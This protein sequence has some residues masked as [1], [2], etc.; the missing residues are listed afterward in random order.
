M[1]L[2]RRKFVKTKKRSD[3][4]ANTI[5]NAE[6]NKET[7]KNT[8]VK[9]VSVN[10][11]VKEIKKE[12]KDLDG[13]EKEVVIKIVQD[14]NYQN[15]SQENKAQEVEKVNFEKPYH[16]SIMPAYSSS[17]N[18]IKDDLR[19]VI[20]EE[21]YRK[22]QFD[23]Q[24]E[25]LKSHINDKFSALS[26][27]LKQNLPYQNQ[28]LL[29][30]PIMQPMQQPVVNSYDFFGG[31]F[32]M[33]SNFTTTPPTTNQSAT[34][35]APNS[36][37]SSTN[38]SASSESVLKENAPKEKE[39]IKIQ[40]NGK[41]VKN[42]HQSINNKKNDT[43]LFKKALSEEVGKV[44]NNLSN[45]L[46]SSINNLNNYVHNLSDALGKKIGMLEKQMS[47]I[48]NKLQNDEN[49]NLD[50]EERIQNVVSNV[51]NDLMEKLDSIERNKV[52]STSELDSKIN[53]IKSA[54]FSKLENELEKNA[55]E[56]RNKA[57]EIDTKLNAI[58]EDVE[59]RISDNESKSFSEPQVVE[60]KVI[61]E[62]IDDNTD[63]DNVNEITTNNKEDLNDID[64]L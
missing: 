55:T 33:N 51:K 27:N 59:T 23:L 20:I 29:Q 54:L 45:K 42:E 15:K 41:E 36:V 28:Q 44:S 6:I 34:T 32:P 21:N 58:V 7:K 25:I 18:T 9:E 57:D 38:F 16:S 30:Q 10:E 8:N 12:M 2:L 17:G 50:M 3:N 61:S 31:K 14:N 22:M 56:I 47:G 26:T 40:K 63:V 62:T 49:E 53:E 24:T 35:I 43:E 46:N 19:S 1:D 60:A 39:I 4:A 11:E 5:S 64:F 37:G 13:K 52:A 48:A